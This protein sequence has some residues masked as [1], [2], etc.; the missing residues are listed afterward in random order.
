MNGYLAH[1][2]FHSDFSN[3]EFV[4]DEKPQVLEKEKVLIPSGWD[5]L[6]KIKMMKTSFAHQLFVPHPETLLDSACIDYQHLFPETLANKIQHPLVLEAEPEQDFLAKHVEVLQSQELASAA[7]SPSG[8]AASLT[9]APG[10][11]N[12]KNY[13][14]TLEDMSAKLARLRVQW[15]HLGAN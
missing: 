8:S 5:T 12:L 6:G 7:E 14:D 11:T 2:L 13:K 10:K 1:H 15:I 9:P 3:N 4:F